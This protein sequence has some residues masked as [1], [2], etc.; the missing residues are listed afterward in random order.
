[1][2]TKTRKSKTSTSKPGAIKAVADV[3]STAKKAPVSKKTSKTVKPVASAPRKEKRIHGSFSMPIS[4]YT[5]IA[6]LK[7]RSKTAGRPVKKN[8]LFRAGLQTL[9]DLSNDALQAALQ[10][11]GPVTTKMRKKSGK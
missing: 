11:L 6:E 10:R 7:S 3:V 5:L 9:G 8:E 1:M 4:D 2:S